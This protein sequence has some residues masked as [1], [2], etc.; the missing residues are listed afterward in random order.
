MRYVVASGMR[1]AVDPVF[2]PSGGRM[3]GGLQ[4]LTIEDL[5]R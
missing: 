2:E 1:L 3:V 5:E 4:L